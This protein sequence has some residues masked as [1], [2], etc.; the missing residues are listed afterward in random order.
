[1]RDKFF[2]KSYGSYGVVV[3]HWGR[4]G[5]SI[6]QIIPGSGS[7]TNAFPFPIIWTLNPS[8]FPNHDGKFTFT[9][10]PDHSI[11]LWKD[12]SL[13]VIVKRFQRFSC[14]VSFML[15]VT[16]GIDIFENSRQNLK[17]TL[18]TL[19]RE[20]GISCK[21]CLFYILSDDWLFDALIVGLR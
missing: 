18:C 15:T 7:F 8:I 11:E 16:W 14:L 3:L 1:M 21:V 10:S 12:L 9:L 6:Y 4:W 2:R 5:M 20:V 17:K 19:P 13:R